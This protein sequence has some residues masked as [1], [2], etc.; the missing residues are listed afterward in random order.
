MLLLHKKKY[1][2]QYILI[3]SIDPGNTNA[4]E[5]SNDQQGNSDR[6]VVK[7]LED[8]EPRATNQGQAQKKE[9]NS[10]HKSHKLLPHVWEDLQLHDWSN[11]SF[12]GSKFTV[13]SQ[14]Y[15]HKEEQHGP[16]R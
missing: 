15:Q 10:D 13:N 1:E 11:G 2:V 4:L 3:I 5:Q 6:V 8:V 14:Q 12:K 9:N 7:Y 16:Q